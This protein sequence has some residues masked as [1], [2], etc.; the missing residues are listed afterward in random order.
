MR[1]AGPFGYDSTS[2]SLVHPYLTLLSMVD[3]HWFYAS[4]TS[5]PEN[6]EPRLPPIRGASA[7]SSPLT[8]RKV[9]ATLPPPPSDRYAIEDITPAEIFFAKTVDRSN[10]VVV[11]G[12]FRTVHCVFKIVDATQ[13]PNFLEE[14]DNEV[15]IYRVLEPL[16]ESDIPTF[17]GYY[18]VWNMLYVLR[19]VLNMIRSALQR[20]HALDVVHGDIRL[21][22]FLY[23]TASGGV[24]V[25]DFGRYPSVEAE[26]TELDGLDFTELA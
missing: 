12:T 11:E 20:L 14:L 15:N 25:I 16:Q 21:L 2:P 5:S 10:A 13:R 8:M 22:N 17:H 6:C 18:R 1:V 26:M 3:E 24:K 19:N 23:D 9:R 7:R 4:P